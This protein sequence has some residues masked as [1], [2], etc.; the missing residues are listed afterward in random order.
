LTLENLRGRQPEPRWHGQGHNQGQVLR[1][2]RSLD[3]VALPM[4]YE[5]RA[6]G[7]GMASLTSGSEM[8]YKNQIAWWENVS[9]GIRPS[10]PPS[11]TVKSGHFY[12]LTTPKKPHS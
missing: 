10:A 7:E 4:P 12:L 11:P 6:D 3:S 9:S 8:G 1:M 5:T 2:L